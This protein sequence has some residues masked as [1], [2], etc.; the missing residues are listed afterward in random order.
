MLIKL[1]VQRYRPTCIE[2]ESTGIMKTI[3]AGAMREQQHVC[4]S[5]KRLNYL[6]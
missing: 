4:T 3:L 2:Y 5:T 6:T 1:R